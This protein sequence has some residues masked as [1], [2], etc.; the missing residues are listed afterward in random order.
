MRPEES[1]GVLEPTLRRV[2]EQLE[3]GRGRSSRDGYPP[4]DEFKRPRIPTV[5]GVFGPRGS[6]K[7]TAL[8]ALRDLFRA[9]QAA[10]A[11]AQAQVAVPPPIDCSLGHPQ[12][13]L[14]LS[15]L[16]AIHRPGIETQPT[17]T[18]TTQ[19]RRELDKAWARV[20]AMILLVENAAGRVL[21]GTAVSPDHYV[22]AA[23][24]Q[25]RDRR[26]LPHALQQWLDL[27]AKTQGVQSFLVCLDDV[28]LAR[29][30]QVRDL[31]RA[32]LDE[33]HQDRLLLVLAADLDR[34]EDST[35]DRAR[36]IDRSTG[37]EMLYK[38]IPE[39]HRVYF[40]PWSP[41]ARLNYQPLSGRNGTAPTLGKLLMRTPTFAGLDVAGGAFL[42][43][44]PRGLED[45]YL[46]LN[47]DPNAA[48][49]TPTKS[50]TRPTAA[51][52]A[53]PAAAPD[54]QRLLVRIAEARREGELARR[55]RH[56][57]LDVAVRSM[58][59]PSELQ[60][61]GR[62]DAL[63]EAAREPDLGLPDLVP[64][65]GALPLDKLED[66]AGSQWAEV[67][68]DLAMAQSDRAGEGPRPRGALGART[69]FP[70][71]ALVARFAPL[72]DRADRARMNEAV[73]AP[74]L[75]KWLDRED[76][77]L[78]AA[79]W[80]VE[81]SEGEGSSPN[82]PYLVGWTA[83]QRFVTGRRELLASA[84]LER[85]AISA[86]G[87]YEI[88][89]ARPELLAPPPPHLL[90][91][92]R[93]LRALLLVVDQLAQVPWRELSRALPGADL[94]H[95][96]T[97][98]Y[99]ACRGAF[100]L[101]HDRLL[102]GE[103]VPPRDHCRRTAGLGPPMDVLSE[104]GDCQDALIE[105]VGSR[106]PGTSGR[107]S[108]ASRPKPDALPENGET[109]ASRAVLDAL[110]RLDRLPCSLVLGRRAQT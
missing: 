21:E 107:R 90:P 50:R 37:E 41:E 96:A 19:G 77:A 66:E 43:P 24:S 87:L 62:W 95:R 64:E 106:A 49:E 15:I 17:H 80:W 56:T 91:L 45:L 1:V 33:L 11:A 28:D 52:A 98:A 55:M 58:R 27:E 18:L 59:W 14:L 102:D 105:A 89:D 71:D 65:S 32:L 40:D 79:L 34:L 94:V 61:Y 67:L 57:S 93:R 25:V 42:P 69:R 99:T 30:S 92:P 13:S 53:R 108:P 47:P 5:F 97:V 44:F 16:E 83:L 88:E 8:L 85:R 78:V 68:L 104:R 70:P 75:Q 82:T 26:E 74:R 20:Q 51:D 7:T 38:A 103:V 110:D 81:L 54:S 46:A 101:A 39:R 35:R 73:E 76:E 12:H 31:V 23:R 6:G 2:L 84:P 63:V 109:P 3:A 86:P 60:R 100:L 72:R 48:R 9:P 22:D 4:W 10:G 36:R 29:T